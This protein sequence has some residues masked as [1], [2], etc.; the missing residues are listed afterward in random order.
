MG[1]PSSHRADTSP[2][3]GHAEWRWMIWHLANPVIPRESTVAARPT[4]GGR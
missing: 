4:C 3:A 1:A 2:M